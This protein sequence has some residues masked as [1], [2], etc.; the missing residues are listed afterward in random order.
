MVDVG[1][2]AIHQG[3][4]IDELGSKGQ[5]KRPNVPIPGRGLFDQ[6]T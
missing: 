5:V 1:A 6:V 4:C 3:N 2:K